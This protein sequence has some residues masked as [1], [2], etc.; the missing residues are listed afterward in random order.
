MS[1]YLLKQIK[2]LAFIIVIIISNS[3]LNNNDCNIHSYDRECR[4]ICDIYAKYEQV[5]KYIE[6]DYNVQSCT[7]ILKKQSNDRVNTIFDNQ[8]FHELSSDTN[9]INCLIKVKR[10]NIENNTFLRQDNLMYE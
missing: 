5:I 1:D 6:E 3:C 4:T 2:N 7:K 8:K 9:V 10:N